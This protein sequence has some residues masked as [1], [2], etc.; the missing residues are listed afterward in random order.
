MWLVLASD[1]VVAALVDIIL[2]LLKCCVVCVDVIINVRIDVFVV[3]D[4]GSFG[5]GDDVVAEVGGIVN[6]VNDVISIVI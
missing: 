6:V 1:V 4:G 2:V 3:V 5:F